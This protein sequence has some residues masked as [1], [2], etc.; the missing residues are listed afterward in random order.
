M[1][2]FMEHNIKGYQIKGLLSSTSKD[3]KFCTEPNEISKIL[4]VKWSAPWTETA[5]GWPQF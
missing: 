1:E 4:L 3:Y 2:H 5:T